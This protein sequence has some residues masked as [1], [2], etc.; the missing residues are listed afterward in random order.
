LGYD[1]KQ[2]LIDP[3]SKTE[4]DST[5]DVDPTPKLDE[6]A[7]QDLFQNVQNLLSNGKDSV[8]CLNVDDFGGKEIFLDKNDASETTTSLNSSSTIENDS[9]ST[10]NS[11]TNNNK[12]RTDNN[13]GSNR[14]EVSGSSSFE[15]L[16]TTETEDSDNKPY[17]V[18]G[19]DC[20]SDSTNSGGSKWIRVV[21]E[22]SST[23]SDASSIL[24]FRRRSF[25]NEYGNRSIYHLPP[26]FRDKAMRS[27]RFGRFNNSMSSGSLHNGPEIV[28]KV[29]AKIVSIDPI[30]KISFVHFT[31]SSKSKVFV[32]VVDEKVQVENK[33]GSFVL[34]QQVALTWLRR[35]LYVDQD[36]DINAIVD[37]DVWKILL[38]RGEFKAQI[39]PTRI[40]VW[41]KLVALSPEL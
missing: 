5:L 33:F 38:I 35:H 7:D 36:V 21:P 23:D 22:A 3:S 11:S 13:R 25:Q 18:N 37:K 24:S 34:T 15:T 19:C 32:E 10:I 39:K 6:P 16:T 1:S 41:S 8:D 14:E 9:T 20:P 2:T 30:I 26:R 28:Y 27:K 12:T 40:K 4:E 31:L 17:E 29:P